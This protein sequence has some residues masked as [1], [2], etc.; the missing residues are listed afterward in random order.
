M[1]LLKEIQ[2]WMSAVVKAW[3]G[4][5]GG[6]SVTVAAGAGQAAGWWILPPRVYV[7]LMICGVIVSMFQA[8]NKEHSQLRTLT[9]LATRSLTGQIDQWAVERT[10]VSGSIIDCEILFQLVLC[11]EGLIPLLLTKCYLQTTDLSAIQNTLDSV[12]LDR[13]VSWDDSSPRAIPDLFALL[14]RVPITPHVPKEVWIGF[15]LRNT[16]VHNFHNLS[17]RVIVVDEKGREYSFGYSGGNSSFSVKKLKPD[18]PAPM[19]IV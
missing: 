19:Q 18:E 17:Y 10:S 12:P 3:T 2:A 13:W 16:S 15:V 7:W 4:W 1:S 9:D 11:N 8:W 5:V 14:K 6:S